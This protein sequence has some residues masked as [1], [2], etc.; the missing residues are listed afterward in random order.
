MKLTIKDCARHHVGLLLKLTRGILTDTKYRAASLRQQS[1]L[2][3]VLRTR[4]FKNK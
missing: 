2:L 1:Y 4:Y 3:S